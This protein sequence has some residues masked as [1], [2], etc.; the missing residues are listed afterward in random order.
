MKFGVTVL[1]A[2]IVLFGALYYLS[3]SRLVGVNTT[4]F[5]AERT[6]FFAPDDHRI[7]ASFYAPKVSGGVKSPALILVHQDYSSRRDFAEF[8]PKFLDEG[9]AVLAYDVRGF[10]KSSGSDAEFETSYLDTIGALDFLQKSRSI[11]MDKICVVGLSMGANIAMAA[12]SADD[13]ISC[14]VAASLSQQANLILNTISSAVP[15][16]NIFV[17]TTEAE[18]EA[19]QAMMAKARE[20]KV[21]KSYGTTIHGKKLLQD[22]ARFDEVIEFINKSLG[23]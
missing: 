5:S 1:I 6:S 22:E 2:L 11:D 7:S 20:P 12:A 13:R 8:I 18:R 15:P 9:F 3:P 17:M 23:L 21:L 14:T 16:K 10:G 19:A 4:R